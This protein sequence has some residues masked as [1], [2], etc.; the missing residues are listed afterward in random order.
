MWRT[1]LLLFF[2]FPLFS[3]CCFP[4]NLHLLFVVSY[5][6]SVLLKYFFTVRPHYANKEAPL[7]FFFGRCSGQGQ[8]YGVPCFSNDGSVAIG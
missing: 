7:Y 6:S 5:K 2:L 3:N 4:C 8:L 1:I